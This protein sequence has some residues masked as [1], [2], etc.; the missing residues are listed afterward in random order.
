MTVLVREGKGWTKSLR[1]VG[2]V[3]VDTRNRIALGKVLELLKDRFGNLDRLHF[4]IHFDD[5][6]GQIVLVPEKT[7]PLREAWLY[8]NPM[9]LKSVTTG[10]RQA[11]AGDLHD[12]GSFERHAE[13]E[14]ED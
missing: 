1:L 8:Q 11:A 2:E 4:A 14:I 5:T 7:I 3:A 13:D 9:A 10:I 6:D 12:L